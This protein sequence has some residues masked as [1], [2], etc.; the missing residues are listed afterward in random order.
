MER[1]LKG[2][3]PEKIFFY[4]EEISKIPRGS[5][6]EKRISDYLYNFAIER[7]LNVV[8]DEALNIIIKKA[9]TKGYENAPVVILQGHMDM[10][11]E[12]NKGT[13]HNFEKDPIKLRIVDDYIYA[14]DTTLGADN[15]MAVAYCLAILDSE[16]ISHPS[17][18]ILITTNEETDYNGVINLDGSQFQGK[19][20]IN[21]DGAEEGSV[22]VGSA[23]G[24]DVTF[25]IPTKMVDSKFKV[26]YRLS[27]N[28]LKGGHSGNDIDKERGNANKLIGR[29][30]YD[31]NKKVKVEVAE[32]NGGTKVNVIPSEAEAVILTDNI[33]EIKHLIKK[34]E[35]IFKNEYIFTDADV[36][37]KIEETNYV[38]KVFNEETISKIL[39]IINNVPNGPRVKS[40]EIDLVIHSNNLGL[41]ETDKNYVI[42]T[43][44][45]RSS[46]KSLNYDFVNS[47]TQLAN[48]LE[49]VCLFNNPYPEW[50]YVKESPIRDLVVDTYE[51]LTGKKAEIKA[52]HAG[53]E[54][55]YL[56]KK[57]G[58]IDVI[59]I[60]P[61]L[62][63]EHSTNEH[64]SISSYKRTYNLLCE[65]LKRIK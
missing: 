38:S 36:Q 46:I 47:M 26:A 32:I 55:G 22:T 51:E 4:F 12:K 33:D 5:R 45:P 39:A 6:N 3:K 52:I 60:G 17:L 19:I 40:T 59:S 16:N 20:L 53:L 37:V 1:I 18:E 64:F 31:I 11:C 23:G 61:D 54:C 28:G 13:N 7:G 21:L 15:G 41:I 48:S 62:F 56:I 63:D 65:V 44:A 27:V 50:E 8:Q 9:A 43:N 14:T 24:A 30:L 35:N 57:L 10:V 49:T 34:W 58:E 42:L 29:I 25:K 2:L